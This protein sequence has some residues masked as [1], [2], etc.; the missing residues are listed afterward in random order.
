MR[1]TSSALVIPFS[2]SHPADGLWVIPMSP[3][4][5]R[6]FR[7][8]KTGNI[9]KEI[10]IGAARP[11]RFNPRFDWFFSIVVAKIP[12]FVGQLFMVRSTLSVKLPDLAEK[13]RL[14]LKVKPPFWM[15]KV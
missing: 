5:W 2:G 4:S 14:F 7:T 6:Y 3:N 8:T 9:S 12:G 10:M 13:K 11:C 1:W 15:V